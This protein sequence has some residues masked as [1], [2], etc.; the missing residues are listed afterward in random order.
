MNKEYKNGTYVDVDASKNSMSPCIV[1][2]IDGEFFS[3]VQFHGGG[4]AFVPTMNNPTGELLSLDFI[5]ID[6]TN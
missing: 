6:Y 3:L 5:E 2:I 4:F 1:E